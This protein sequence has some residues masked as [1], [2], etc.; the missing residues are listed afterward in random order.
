MSMLYKQIQTEV[1]SNE[2]NAYISLCTYCVPGKCYKSDP[3]M[4]Y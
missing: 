1:S 3:H 4:K 2:L